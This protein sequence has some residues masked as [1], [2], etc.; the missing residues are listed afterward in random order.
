M[1]SPRSTPRSWCRYRRASAGDATE[2]TRSAAAAA[3][4]RVRGM[5]R[6]AIGSCQ[7]TRKSTPDALSAPC[8]Y[9]VGRK[10]KGPPF[11]REKGLVTCTR[12]D[13]SGSVFQIGVIIDRAG[14]LDRTSVV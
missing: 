12:E 9:E 8:M 3:L 2:V 6:M 10:G 11:L 13:G 14:V 4:D 5:W 7:F 1:R